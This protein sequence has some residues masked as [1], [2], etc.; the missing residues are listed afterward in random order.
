[1]LQARGREMARVLLIGIWKGKLPV[2]IR[3]KQPMPLLV[4]FLSALQQSALGGEVP[5]PL[6]FVTK[7][8]QGVKLEIIDG[9]HDVLT[10]P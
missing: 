4:R 5:F 1:M 9:E 3:H 8:I 7:F 10:C 6:L 2:T